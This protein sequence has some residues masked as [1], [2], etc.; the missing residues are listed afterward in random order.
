[1]L[2]DRNPGAFTLSVS[3]TTRNPRQG[4]EHGVHYFFVAKDDFKNLQSKDGFV[5]RY[6]NIFPRYWQ[7]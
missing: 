7:V 5:E 6:G 2:F 4:E 3:H 1:M